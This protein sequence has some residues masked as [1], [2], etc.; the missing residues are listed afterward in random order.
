MYSLQ[1]LPSQAQGPEVTPQKTFFAHLPRSEGCS[2]CHGIPLKGLFLSPIQYA[3]LAQHF[4]CA[5][6]DIFSFP[7]FSYCRRF[8]GPS[9]NENGHEGPFSHCL[10]DALIRL[11]IS[12][13]EEEEEPGEGNQGHAADRREGDGALASIQG[14]DGFRG[15]LAGVDPA[16]EV[17]VSVGAVDGDGKVVSLNG[18]GD[19]PF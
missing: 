6:Q 4:P 19:V 8:E 14:E 9:P 2:T 13:A 15:K 3:Q 12:L 17:V 16:H 10:G 11:D 5:F 18:L 7:C 1:F